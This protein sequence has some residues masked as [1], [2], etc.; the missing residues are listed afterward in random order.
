MKQFITI[1]FV[2]AAFAAG[3]AAFAL[4]RSS[5]HQAAQAG[6]HVS[7]QPAAAVPSSGVFLSY[8]CERQKSLCDLLAY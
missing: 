8:A 5:H 2:L 3:G 1:A 7:D 4:T 6:P